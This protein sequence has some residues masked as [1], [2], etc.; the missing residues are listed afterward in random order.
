[1]I[2]ENLFS[3]AGDRPIHAGLIGTGTYGISLISQ[4][5]GGKKSWLFSSPEGTGILPRGQRI[6]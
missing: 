5:H 2:Y 3:R 6:F 1:M 4:K